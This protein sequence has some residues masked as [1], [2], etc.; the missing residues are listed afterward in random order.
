MS[1]W[2]YWTGQD[3]ELE[4]ARQVNQHQRDLN[5]SRYNEGRITLAQYQANLRLLEG[6]ASD[7]NSFDSVVQDTFE[8]AVQENVQSLADT[9]QNVASGVSTGLWQVIPWQLKVA[10]VAILAGLVWFYVVPF[11]KARV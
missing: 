7:I 6:N 2:S 10:V 9:V 5:L 1:F 4:T 8:T 3:D 11:F